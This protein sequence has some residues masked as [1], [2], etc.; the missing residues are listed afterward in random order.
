MNKKEIDLIRELNR[1]IPRDE[2]QEYKSFNYQLDKGQGHYK[3]KLLAKFARG[4]TLD[5]GFAAHPNHFLKNPIGVDIAR[6]PKPSNYEAVYVADA[7]KLPFKDQIFDT[8]IAGDIIE[9][10]ENPS[11]FLRECN[12]VLKKE[13]LLILSTPNPYFLPMIFLDTFMIRRYYFTDSHINLFPQR[14]VLKLLFRNNFL[15]KEIVG[16]GIYLKKGLITIPA[17]KYIS[18]ELIYISKKITS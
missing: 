12:R 3:L 4:K 8:V 18:Q 7:H 16:A 11:K 14:I 9:H 1:K 17:P 15:L 2:V 6:V 10:L 5:I 13:G